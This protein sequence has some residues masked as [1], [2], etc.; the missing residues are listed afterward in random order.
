MQHSLSDALICEVVARNGGYEEVDT[1]SKW[2]QIAGALGFSKSEASRIKERYEDLLKY[3]A[4]LEEARDSPSAN[5][6]V[7]PW[8]TD[9]GCSVSDPGFPKLK[10]QTSMPFSPWLALWLGSHVAPG[11]PPALA[12]PLSRENALG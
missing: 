5:S 8:R 7:L 2:P 3:T 1:N 11:P 12:E 9:A 10:R 6:A 4:E